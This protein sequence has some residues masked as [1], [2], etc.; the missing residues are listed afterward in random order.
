MSEW[1]LTLAALFILAV[2]VV[3]LEKRNP[4]HLNGYAQVVDGDSLIINGERLRLQGID[5]P[6]FDQSCIVSG[7]ATPCGQHARNALRKLVGRGQVACTA[8]SV[9]R[10]DR[11]LATCTAGDMNINQTLVEQGWA[12]DYGGY[13]KSEAKA[14]Q[15]KLGL[16]QGTFQRPHDW[17]ALRKGSLVDAEEEASLVQTIWWRIRSFKFN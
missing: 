12:V 2:V 13:A 11:W 6:E 17:R 4:V 1:L 3:W 8:H 5:A 16:W 10:H 9:D 15:R 14:R 7:K